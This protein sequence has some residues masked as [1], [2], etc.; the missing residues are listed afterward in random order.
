[1]IREAGNVT[2]VG[3]R[4]GAYRVLVRGK[5]RERGH[6]QEPNIDGKDHIKMDQQ[7]VE[8]EHGLD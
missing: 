2:L 5:P 8:S 6:L 7:L 3:Y 1:M 4:R